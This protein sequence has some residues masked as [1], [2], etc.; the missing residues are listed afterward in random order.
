MKRLEDLEL[1]ETLPEAISQD[2]SMRGFAYALQRQLH[3]LAKQSDSG[4]WYKNIDKA[5]SAQ[6]DHIAVEHDLQVWRD[7]WPLEL[8]RRVLKN[9]FLAKSKVGTVSAV[10]DALST[11]GAAAEIV[12][13]WQTEPKGAPHTFNIIA[14][15]SQIEGTLTTEMQEDLQLMIKDS[16]PVRSHFTFQ[17]VIA[18]E[19]GICLLGYARAAVMSRI[20]DLS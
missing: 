19:G 6:L 9:A 15:L 20:S 11:I 5:T 14:T 8:K 2:I 17:I 10:R 7:K 16:K 3:K 13:W 18:K 1:V 4:A 12:E